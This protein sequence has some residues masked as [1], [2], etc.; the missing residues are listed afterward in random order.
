MGVSRS[1]SVRRAAE[2][3]LHGWIG[4]GLKKWES[5]TGTS[6]KALEGLDSC[7]CDGLRRKCMEYLEL[8]RKV[9]SSG[10][11]SRLTKV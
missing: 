6:S 4:K 7:E 10:T 1:V 9:N 8:L 3:L 11:N 5:F 2:V